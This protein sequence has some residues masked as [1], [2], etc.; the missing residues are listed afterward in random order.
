L[1]SFLLVKSLRL[2][3]IGSC[4]CSEVDAEIDT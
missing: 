1:L 2:A 3:G 4:D